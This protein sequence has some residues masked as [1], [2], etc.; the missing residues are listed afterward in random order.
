MYFVI[1]DLNQTLNQIV[2]GAN[3]ANGTGRYSLDIVAFTN[4]YAKITPIETGVSYGND[5]LGQ[6]ITN[7][8]QAVQNAL[9]TNIAT[10]LGIPV[11]DPNHVTT[12]SEDQEIRAKIDDL[13]RTLGDGVG[14][15]SNN[16]R[17]SLYA[18]ECLR[19]RDN[20]NNLV[21]F[22]V[23]PVVDKQN[24]MK[25]IAVFWQNGQTLNGMQQR[26]IDTL[27]N[28]VEASQNVGF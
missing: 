5:L 13:V 17:D 27:Y 8:R 19:I 10:G 12:S 9:Y 22:L 23:M 11:T 14:M 1:P 7:V 26:G 21:S 18:V 28:A 6:P 25:Y 15:E 16:E 2:A 20:A 4:E 3:G 24:S